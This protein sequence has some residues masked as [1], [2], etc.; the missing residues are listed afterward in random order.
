MEARERS[1]AVAGRFYPDD[2]KALSAAVRACLPADTAPEPARALV[3]PHAGYRYSGRVAGMAFASAP[4]PKT[5]VVLGPNHTGLGSYRA[6]WSAGAWRLPGAAVPVASDLAEE[7]VR[8]AR[9]VPDTDAHL[10]EHSLEVEL[11]FLR[12]LQP[13]LRIVPVCLGP[14][15][16]RDCLEL[17]VA[18]SEVIRDFREPV[19]LVASTDMSHYISAERA[20]ALDAMALERVA[21]LDAEGLY[22]VVRERGISM[23]G[24]VPT[25]VALAAA[26]ALGAEGAKVLAYENS[27]NVSGDHER[28]VGYAA[29]RVA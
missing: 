22:A 23:C 20:A 1:P 18:L 21:A 27:S 14:L 8:R 10:M 25:T 5:V 6:V 29:A 26:R 16:R 19:L 15:D 24:V 7:L 11:P 4:I 12:E 9:L 2:A 13:E 3:A 28:V 17:G